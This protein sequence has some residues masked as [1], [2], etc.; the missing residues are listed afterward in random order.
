MKSLL[1]ECVTFC[2]GILFVMGNHD[3]HKNEVL[4]T[5]SRDYQ[6]LCIHVCAC[7]C[8]VAFIAE[9]CQEGKC[10]MEAGLLVRKPHIIIIFDLHKPNY[11]IIYN[12]PHA[13][14][15]FHISGMW[16][17]NTTTAR[18]YLVGS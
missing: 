9:S 11:Y 14:G 7:V 18:T 8:R 6:G 17:Y 13:D 16:I 10:W 3:T 1:L 5:N 15:C 4:G 2:L 12:L